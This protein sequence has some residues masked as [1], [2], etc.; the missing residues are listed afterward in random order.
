MEQNSI[1]YELKEINMLLTRTA[2]KEAKKNNHPPMSPPQVRIINYLLRQKKEKVYQKDLE[3]LLGLRRSTISGILQTMEKNKIIKRVG[4]EEDARIKQIILTEEAIKK[5][6][7]FKKSIQSI[8]KR[9]AQKISKK[10]LA[11]FFKLTA[12]M[13]ENIKEGND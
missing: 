8:E 10:E 1:L 13:K 6:K 3:K 12:Q 9:L 11:L 2:L 7:E 5:D 4:I